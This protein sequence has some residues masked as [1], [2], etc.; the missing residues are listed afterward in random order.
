M[1][2]IFPKIVLALFAVPATCLMLCTI[3][4]EPIH[5]WMMRHDCPFAKWAMHPPA[6]PIPGRVDLTGR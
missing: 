6:R 4:V 1:T 5:S 3:R 2:A